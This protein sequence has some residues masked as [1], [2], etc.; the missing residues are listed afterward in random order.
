MALRLQNIQMWKCNSLRSVTGQNGCHKHSGR[1]KSKQENWKSRHVTWILHPSLFSE[2]SSICFCIFPFPACLDNGRVMAP[3]FF[4]SLF[5]FLQPIASACVFPLS[6]G[7]R[8]TKCSTNI[9]YIKYK[10]R[11]RQLVPESLGHWMLVDLTTLSD[12]TNTT[13]MQHKYRCN[14]DRAQIQYKYSSN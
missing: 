13:Q 12:T 6:L 8:L 11:N 4:Q 14:T 1:S 9:L 5:S 7:C 2:R 3:L 10:Y